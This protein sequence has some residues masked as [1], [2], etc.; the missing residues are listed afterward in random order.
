MQRIRVGFIGLGHN[1]LAHIA[2]HS[3]SPLSEV[4]AV[5]DYSPEKTA[6]AAEKFGAPRQYHDYSILERDDIDAI[7]IHTPDH[8]HAEPFVL[9]LEAGKHVFVEKPMGNSIEDLNRMVDAAKR[10]PRQKT[11]VGHILRFNPVFARVKQ[12]V[13]EGALGD[14]FYMECDYVHNLRFQG[15]APRFDPN[16]GMNWYLEKEIPMVGGG[17]HPFDLLKWFAGEPAVEVTGF[18]NRKAFP[19]M[20]ND[21]CQVCLF[22]FASGAIAKVAASYGCVAPYAFL[23]NLIVYGTKGTVNR[24]TICL[25]AHPEAYRALRV[26]PPSG[27]PYEPEVVY[28]HTA[29]TENRPTLIDAFDGANSAAAVI[30]GAQAA[31][32]GKPLPI[33]RYER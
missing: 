18:S 7:S 1:G 9:A 25:K 30:R 4:V 5:C 8:L 11:M 15:D 12:L 28:N 22:R 21:D 17:G 16:I 26:E 23:N 31:S 19:Q 10:H 33:P 3:R 29:T 13:Q 24:N 2:A 27:H 14:L 32:E 20:V 6:A